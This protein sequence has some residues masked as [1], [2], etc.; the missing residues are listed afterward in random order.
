MTTNANQ[1]SSTVPQCKQINSTCV[2]PL[3]IIGNN[4]F[5]IKGN[6]KIDPRLIPDTSW[7]NSSATKFY[8]VL[9]EKEAKLILEKDG[10]IVW[11]GETDENGEAEFS[12]KVDDA[13]FMDTWFLKDDFGNSVEVGFF[14][15]TPIKLENANF[16]N[17]QLVIGVLITLFI[18]ITLV[19]LI[20]KRIK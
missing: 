18:I 15:E 9:G 8:N 16:R 11:S 19:F 5:V 2:N 12:I 7:E 13:T 4:D 3:I 20:R 14:S 6:C 17:L 1:Y 10:E